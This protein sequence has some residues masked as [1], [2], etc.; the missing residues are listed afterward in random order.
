MDAIKDKIIELIIKI[1]GNEPC[2]NISN[3]NL[4]LTGFTMQFDEIDLVYLLLEVMKTFNIKIKAEDVMNYRFN[5]I[6][7]IAET[8]RKYSNEI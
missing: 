5:T 7:Q 4:P 6:D 1:K 3:S 2:Y 8:V